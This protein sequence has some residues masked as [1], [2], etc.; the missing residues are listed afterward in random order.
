M[1]VIALADQRARRGG[2]ADRA[3]DL[4]I[5]GVE[6][7]DRARGHDRPIA[8]FEIGDAAGQRRQRQRVRA[9]EHLAIAIADRQRAAAAGADQQIVLAGEQ[10]D[11]REG[12]FEP[13]QGLR[14]RLLRRQSLIEEMRRQDRHRLGVGLGLEA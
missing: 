11:E 13:R 14:H 10:E 3:L 4:G 8:L 5:L 12:A 2:F 9:D 1:A 6:D 7:R